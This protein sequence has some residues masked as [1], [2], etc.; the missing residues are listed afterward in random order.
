MEEYDSEDLDEED[1][2]QDEG[3]IGEDCSSDDGSESEGNSVS[4]E[5]EIDEDGNIIHPSEVVTVHYHFDGVD[6]EMEFMADDKEM[7]GWEAYC[8]C[9]PY[10]EDRR[11]RVI[12]HNYYQIRYLASR[13]DSWDYY[14]MQAEEIMMHCIFVPLTRTFVQ[15]KILDWY[16][17]ET[18]LFDEL[19]HDFYNWDYM[20]RQGIKPYEVASMKELLHNLVRKLKSGWEM[21][22]GVGVGR[23][24][25]EYMVI[26]DKLNALQRM[27]G[28]ERRKTLKKKHKD[29]R[30]KHLA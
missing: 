23:D 30:R 9:Y 15:H 29:E 22:T 19:R 21:Q 1:Y 5:E 24:Q 4:S 10:D 18:N 7:I 2:A 27:G 28:E 17:G 25:E 3:S 16:N 12:N 11:M 14:D 8:Y 20:V 6:H 13:E 26:C